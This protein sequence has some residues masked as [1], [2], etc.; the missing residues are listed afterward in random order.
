[1]LFYHSSRAT[2]A[3]TTTIHKNQIRGMKQMRRTK[4]VRMNA[5][6]RQVWAPR[7]I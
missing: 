4:A 2:T 1:M 5:K 7:N 3:S 6:K